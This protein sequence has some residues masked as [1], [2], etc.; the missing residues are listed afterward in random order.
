[1]RATCTY[2][3][4]EASGVSVWKH[5]AGCWYASAVDRSESVL[6]EQVHIHSIRF[7][8]STQVKNKYYRLSN[9]FYFFHGTYYT[10]MYH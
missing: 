6:R 8:T 2:L 3:E 7:Q 10:Q 4:R 9:S 1:M 5:A